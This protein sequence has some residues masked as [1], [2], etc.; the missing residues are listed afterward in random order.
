MHIKSINTKGGYKCIV[1]GLNY[2]IGFIGGKDMGSSIGLV[3][4]RLPLMWTAFTQAL[5]VATLR[6]FFYAR[7]D[8][9]LIV[10]R[11]A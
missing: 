11:P 5:T 4:S 10:K 7:F 6:S 2:P 3:S 9:V 1:M 8:W